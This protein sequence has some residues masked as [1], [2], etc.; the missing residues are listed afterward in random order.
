MEDT[1]KF[2]G[3]IFVFGFDSPTPSEQLRNWIGDLNLGGLILFSRNTSDLPVLKEQI[4]SLQNQALIPLLVMIDQEGG[5]TNRITYGIPTFPGN[6]F[7]GNRHDRQGLQNA[8]ATTARHLKQLG[9]N[10]C[11]APVVDVL[12][13]PKNILLQER[14]FGSDPLLVAEY[15]TLAVK[16][17]HSEGVAACAK[18]FPGLGDVVVDPHIDLPHNN[19]PSQRFHQVD[20][21]PFKTVIQA[22]CELVMTTHIF[23]PHLDEQHPATF[24]SRIA[25]ELLRKYLGFDGLVITDDLEMGAIVNRESV[26]Q[27]SLKAFLAGH[28]LLL[29]CHSEKLQKETINLFQSAM[30]TNLQLQ[31]RL[32]ESLTRIRTLKQRLFGHA[33]F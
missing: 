33:A 30:K 1:Q 26:P 17:L 18:H 11:L 16:A 25:N 9:I 6:R 2:L 28:D 14:S 21:P 13:N 4:T 5:Q 15:G 20:F 22:G 29:I 8:Y 10:V 27:A 12:T 19:S 31:V 23:C 24:S 3:Q 32:E 7:F